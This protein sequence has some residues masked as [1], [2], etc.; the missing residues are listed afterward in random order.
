VIVA[1]YADEATQDE[2]TPETLLAATLALGVAVDQLTKPGLEYLD[3]SPATDDA[4]QLVDAEHAAHARD[5]QAAHAL[6]LH[7]RDEI[8]VLRARARITAHALR[9]RKRAVTR[10]PL[11][12]LLEQLVDAVSGR[13]SPGNRA[14]SIHRAAIGFAAAEL[15]ANIE[16]G[17]RH[18]PGDPDLTANVRAW[19]EALVEA[20]N[21]TELTAAAVCAERWVIDARAILTPDQV[22]PIPFDCP[23]CGNRWAWVF[24]DTGQRVQRA[25]LQANMRDLVIRCVHHGCTGWWPKPMWKLLGAQINQDVEERAATLRG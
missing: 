5:L 4:V 6:A 1:D 18:R 12:P 15:I 11:P 14:G 2:P 3:R 25:A 7:Q 20:Q 10:A 8:G 23:T 13:T 21:P 22:I 9:A 19:T 17:T 16:R 24:D